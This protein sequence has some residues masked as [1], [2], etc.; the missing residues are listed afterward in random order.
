MIGK[1]ILPD[2]NQ[3]VLTDDGDI[4]VTDPDLESTVSPLFRSYKKRYSPALGPF[5]PSFLHDLSKKLGG[6]VQLEPKESRP[7]SIY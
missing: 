3:I 5:G 4:G 1:L 6:T 7:D 2:G